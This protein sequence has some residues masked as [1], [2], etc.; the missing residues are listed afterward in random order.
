[1]GDKTFN[2]VEIKPEMISCHL[3]FARP[4]QSYLYIAKV[5][6]LVVSRHL[7]LTFVLKS[8]IKFI[9]FPQF[10]VLFV[11]LYIFLCLV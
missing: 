7:G 9:S 10:M 1:M 6:L 5:L 3:L 11:G 8:L 4:P 2:Q